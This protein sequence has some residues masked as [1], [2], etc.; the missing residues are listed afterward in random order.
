MIK[1]NNSV[2]DGIVT[3]SEFDNLKQDL[4]SIQ[5]TIGQVSV[6]TFLVD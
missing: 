3:A 6:L 1:S 4:H 2:M 5:D